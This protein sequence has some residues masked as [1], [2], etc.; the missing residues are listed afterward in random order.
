MELPLFLP[1][2]LATLDLQ[3]PNEY[4][5]IGVDRDGNYFLDAEPISLGLLQSRLRA[6]GAEN[7]D[8]KIRLD[9]DRAAPFQRVMQVLD[10]LRFEGLKNVGVN[11]RKDG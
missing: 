11:T 10:M 3:Q 6:Q 2:A 1:E 4:V 8:I 9:A 5:A 7:V